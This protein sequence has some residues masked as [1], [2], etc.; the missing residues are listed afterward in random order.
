MGVT[1]NQEKATGEPKRVMRRQE[2]M[3]EQRMGGKGSQGNPQKDLGLARDHQEATQGGNPAG[4][5]SRR[6]NDSKIQ[7]FLPNGEEPEL[8]TRPGGKRVEN[9]THWGEEE[10]I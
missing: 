7:D 3:G 4:A 6:E 1:R 5:K 8:T 9:A 10:N 2:A